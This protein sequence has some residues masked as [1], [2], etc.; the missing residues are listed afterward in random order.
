MAISKKKK[1]IIIS[2]IAAAVIAAAVVLSVLLL[3]SGG[4]EPEPAFNAAEYTVKDGDRVKAGGD[5]KYR[6]IGEAPSG[7]TLSDKGVFTVGADATDGAQV[8]VG[9]VKGGKVV[10]TAVCTVKKPAV[11]PVIAFEN[12]SD[13]IVSGES[14]VAAATPACSLDYSLK[15]HVDGVFIDGVTG[16]VRLG[17]HVADGTQFTVVASAK[18][19]SAER[20]FMASVGA[21]VSSTVNKAYV[22]YGVGGR[23]TV[24]LD[25]GGDATAAAGGVKGVSLAGKML[26]ADKWS[27][28]G[29]AHEV[30]VLA[31][32]FSSLVMGESDMRIY[33]AR[34][35]VLVKITAAKMIRTAEELAAIKSTGA[36]NSALSLHYVL[37]NDIDLTEYLAGSSIGWT[38]IGIYHD[39]TDGTALRDAFSGTFDGNGYTVSGLWM[40]RSDDLAYNGG[41]FGFITASAT[42]V[43][44]NV[45]GAGEGNS[46]LYVKSFSG[47]L[48]GVNNGVVKNCSANIKL[49]QDGA[50]K[51]GGLVGRNFGILEN[52][53]TVGSINEGDGTRIGALCGENTGEIK[54]CY[55]VGTMRLCGENLGTVEGN[56]AAHASVEALKAADFSAFTDWTVEAGELPVLPHALIAEEG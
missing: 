20:T 17:G 44:L 34:N 33:T 18:G 19:E 32:A 14:V 43:N 29:T 5:V 30:T 48:V 36:D 11:K 23:L 45:T 22:E 41:L 4:A 42:I 38:P 52:C 51:C 35:A 53:Y 54:N 9:A 3:P 21:H 40:N 1:I 8:L 12:L 7:V 26:D 50:D 49:I 15:S 2:C 6:I 25:F 31:P 24:P 16:V 10:S 37:A 47:A 27:Y 46:P 55:A 39:V 56:D 28:D 13:Y